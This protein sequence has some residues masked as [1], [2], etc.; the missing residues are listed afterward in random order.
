MDVK[1]VAGEGSGENEK[2]TV[3]KEQKLDPCY[4]VAWT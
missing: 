1:S 4:M 3:G 2:H